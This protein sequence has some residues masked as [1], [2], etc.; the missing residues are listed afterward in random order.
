MTDIRDGA[1]KQCLLLVLVH[2]ATLRSSQLSQGT[3]SLRLG[4][5]GDGWPE[6]NTPSSRCRLSLLIQHHDD[7]SVEGQTNFRYAGVLVTLRLVEVDHKNCA[8]QSA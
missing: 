4:T 2:A 8:T 6:G 1:K 7:T 3:L 5:G